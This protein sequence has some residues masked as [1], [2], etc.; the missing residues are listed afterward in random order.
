[1][2]IKAGERRRRADLQGDTSPLRG[3]LYANAPFASANVFV[4]S[5]LHCFC[6]QRAAS[7]FAYANLLILWDGH[8]V[9]T[10]FKTVVASQLSATLQALASRVASRRA[11]PGE[12]SDPLIRIGT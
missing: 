6:S 9:C 3:L 7:R 8:F 1:M 2:G 11:T 10:L 4:R 12:K 5:G